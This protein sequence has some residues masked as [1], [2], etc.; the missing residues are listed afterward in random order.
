MATYYDRYKQFKVDGDIKP[1][2]GIRILDGAQDKEVLYKLGQTRLD[3]LSQEYYGNPYHGWLILAANP[4]FG[5]L[6]WDI[7]DRTIIRIP[8]PF[9]DAISRY[10]AEVDRYITLYG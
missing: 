4:R 5:G 9:K 3:K 6:E 8:F 7:P 2:P 10:K 1:M